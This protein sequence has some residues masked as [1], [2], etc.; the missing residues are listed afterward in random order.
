MRVPAWLVRRVSSD[1]KVSVSKANLLACC[2]LT[3]R[4]QRSVRDLSH[5]PTAM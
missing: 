3:A 5:W 2:S 4:L 1:D